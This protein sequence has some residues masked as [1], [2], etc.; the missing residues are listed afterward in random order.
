MYVPNF[1]K[2]YSFYNIF[3]THNDNT[4]ES[5][6]QCVRRIIRGCK[7][8]LSKLHTKNQRKDTGTNRNGIPRLS[9]C[10]WT[11][12]SGQSITLDRFLVL[13]GSWT[14]LNSARITIERWCWPNTMNPVSSW[15]VY[16]GTSDRMIGT[17]RPKYHHNAKMWYR[18]WEIGTFKS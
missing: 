11:Q 8:Y 18:I 2:N 13:I 1:E 7:N 16:E 12:T 4:Q 9:G 5:D 15:L 14:I 3:P 17:K 10:F 6:K